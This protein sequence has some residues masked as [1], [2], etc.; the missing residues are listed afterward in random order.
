MA[1]FLRTAVTAARAAPRFSNAVVTSTAQRSLST[2]IPGVGKGKTSTGLVGL[3]VDPDALP[4]MITKYGALLDKVKVMPETAQYRI[5]IEQI[6]NHRIKAA[7]DHPEDP[8]KVE[9][10]CNCGQVEELVVQA[11]DEMIVMDMYIKNRWWEYVK[12]VEIEYEPAEDGGHG[13][14]DW[15]SDIKKNEESS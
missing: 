9:E 6:C 2:L 5:N 14:V 7:T 11:D 8:E 3:A 12:P 10:L 13:D 4:K 15:D 1:S